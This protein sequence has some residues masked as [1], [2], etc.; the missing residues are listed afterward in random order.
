MYRGWIQGFPKKLGSIHVTRTFPVGR[1][2]PHG[3][4]PGRALRRDLRGE[5]PRRSR[6]RS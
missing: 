5:R 4:A 1:A 2:A 3:I 6:A